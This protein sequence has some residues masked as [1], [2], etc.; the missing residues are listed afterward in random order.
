MARSV[1]EQQARYR[2]LAALPY[3]RFRD[4]IYMVYR[5]L[6]C[7]DVLGDQSSLSL[8]DRGPSD[9]VEQGGL[10]MVNMTKDTNDRLSGGHGLFPL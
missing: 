5:H 4:P 6:G 2:E 9:A 8:S 7:A 3:E 10:A 1:D